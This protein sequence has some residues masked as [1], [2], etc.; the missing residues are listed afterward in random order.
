MQPRDFFCKNTVLLVQAFLTSAAEKTKTQAE[1]SSQKL[2]LS[3]NLWGE[4]SHIFWSLG[5]A[6]C[7]KLIKKCFLTVSI[8]VFLAW[9]AVMNSRCHQRRQRL[10]SISRLFNRTHPPPRWQL[11]LPH[12]SN[13]VSSSLS[14]KRQVFKQSSAPNASILQL[15]TVKIVQYWLSFLG[16]HRIAK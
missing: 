3:R 2:N 12:H 9:A 10:P 16:T 6:I 1:N 4:K 13:N 5:A 11:K 7:D 8:P 15:Y 14:L